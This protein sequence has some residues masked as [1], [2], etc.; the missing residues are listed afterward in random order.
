VALVA[1]FRRSAAL[2]DELGLTEQERA[3]IKAPAGLDIKARTAPEVALSILAEVIEVVRS[4]PAPT[5]AVPT[6]RPAEAI[7]PVCGMTVTI[8][9]TT[10]HLTLD[11]QEFWFCGTGCRDRYAAKTASASAE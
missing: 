6:G 5:P 10:P 8:G 7:D 11:S 2:F 9:G 3:R 4:R 1:S